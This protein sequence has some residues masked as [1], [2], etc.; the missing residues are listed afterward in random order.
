M[1]PVQEPERDVAYRSAEISSLERQIA[2][3]QREIEAVL[4]GVVFGERS[5]SGLPADAKE[6]LKQIEAARKELDPARRDQ[7]DAELVDALGVEFS[8]AQEQRIA[9]LKEKKKELQEGLL[10][11]RRAKAEADAEHGDAT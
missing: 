3:V 11:I 5:P 1:E 6:R 7:L 4:E 2:D 10:E 9:E 8:P